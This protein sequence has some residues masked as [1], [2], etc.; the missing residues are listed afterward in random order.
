MT[1]AAAVIAVLLLSALVY[2]RHT[3]DVQASD[4]SIFL[5]VL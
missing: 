5:F 3:A 4:D 1:L 2:T